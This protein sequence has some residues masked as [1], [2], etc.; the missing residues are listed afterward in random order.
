MH[1]FILNLCD[2]AVIILRNFITFVSFKLLNL[3][4]KAECIGATNFNQSSFFQYNV[5]TFLTGMFEYLLFN[6]RFLWLNDL[7]IPYELFYSRTFVVKCFNLYFLFM[8]KFI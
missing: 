1:V 7:L 3:F 4:N 8:P 6:H 2:N 5:F